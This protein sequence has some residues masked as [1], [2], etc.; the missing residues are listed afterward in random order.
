MTEKTLIAE[1]IERDADNKGAP[2]R[3]RWYV[4]EIAHEQIPDTVR[5]AA[6]AAP[7]PD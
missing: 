5:R 7:D 2:L 6:I 1:T 3:V 4:S